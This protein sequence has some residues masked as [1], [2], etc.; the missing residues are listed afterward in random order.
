MFVR[1]LF[2]RFKWVIWVRFFNG[3]ASEIDNTNYNT[4]VLDMSL[5]DWR[6]Q[7]SR[8]DGNTKVMVQFG[9]PAVFY[10]SGF[11]TTF[12]KTEKY[13]FCTYFKQR[14]IRLMVP[15]ILGLIILLPPRMYLS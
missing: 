13:T 12:W 1:E 8:T 11:A 15:F 6:H 5:E 14:F 4:G 2:V 3:V 9:I 7:T 10:M